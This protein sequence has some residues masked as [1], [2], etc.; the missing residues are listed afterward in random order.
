MLKIRFPD[1]IV[2]TNII[3][4]LIIKVFIT[5]INFKKRHFP[6]PEI[7]DKAPQV[8]TSCGLSF[9]MLNGRYDWRQAQN[10]G[11]FNDY[12][13]KEYI[14]NQIRYNETEEAKNQ[15]CGNILSLLVCPFGL[16]S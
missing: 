16:F 3:K 2:N 7:A 12:A 5:F 9:F 1:Q 13:E 15:V 6:Q 10:R 11:V 14:S 4:K 8:G